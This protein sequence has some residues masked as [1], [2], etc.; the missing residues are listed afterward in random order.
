MMMMIPLENSTLG[1]EINVLLNFFV[2]DVHR[3]DEKK[4]H[5][6][7][8]FFL[9]NQIAGK[10]NLCMKLFREQSYQRLIK[11]SE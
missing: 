10:F 3:M 5:K 1:K 8:Q 2:A 4:K 9:P 11:R 7:S 6:K